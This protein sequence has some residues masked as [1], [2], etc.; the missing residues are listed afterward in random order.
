MK[1]G[2]YRN[3]GLLYLAAGLPGLQALILGRLGRGG[4]PYVALSLL[5]LPIGALFLVFWRQPRRQATRSEH[6]V[7][8]GGFALLQVAFGVGSRLVVGA[9]FDGFLTAYWFFGMFSSFL[10]LIAA[11]LLVAALAGG[12]DGRPGGTPV[13]PENE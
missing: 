8:L 13:S 12:G 4:D 5:A 2:A 10:S 11:G 3:V 7:R 9:G 1:P 6:A